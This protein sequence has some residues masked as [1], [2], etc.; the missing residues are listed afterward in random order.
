MNPVALEAF[1]QYTKSEYPKEACGFLVADG[2]KQVFV[3]SRNIADKPLEDFTTHPE[4]YLIA[5]SRGTIIALCHSHPDARASASPS[6]RVACETS[7]MPWYILSWPGNELERIEPSGYTAPLLG[8]PFVHGIHDCYA[9]VRDYY[10]RELRIELPDFDRPAEWWYKGRDA[11]GV[12]HDYRETPVA[13]WG[14][15]KPFDLLAENFELAGFT[16]VSELKPNDG[17]MMQ[18]G[19]RVTVANHTAVYLGDGIMLHHM[20]GQLSARAAFGG[21]W[22]KNSRGFFRHRDLM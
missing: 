2:R 6:D 10:Q 22:L 17:I 5:K 20:Y 11:Q 15:Y 19:P 13:D 12:I 3:P 9:L 21:Y 8:R 4:D 7:K 1:R 18:L 16:R 14:K